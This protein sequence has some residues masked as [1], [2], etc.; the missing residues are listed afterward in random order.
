MSGKPRKPPGR[1]PNPAKKLDRLI[2]LVP[3]SLKDW[4]ITQGGSAFVREMLE[5]ARHPPKPNK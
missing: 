5:R 4:T 2:V 3:A 1:R